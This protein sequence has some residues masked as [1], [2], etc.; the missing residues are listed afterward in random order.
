MLATIMTHSLAKLILLS[1]LI[2]VNVLR[3]HSQV[4]TSFLQKEYSI[5]PLKTSITIDGV[6]EEAEW[7]TY[8][9][10]DDF[11]QQGPEDGIKAAVATEV[12]VTYNDQGIFLA[13][14]LDDD[15]GQVIN[16]LKRDNMA[17]SDAFF[18]VLDPVNK[19]TN[20]FAFGVN[21]AG[22]QAE[23]LISPNDGDES[24]DNRWR[25]ATKVYTDHWTVEMFVPF[26]TLRFDNNN[27]EWG[28]NFV[29]FETGL[30]ESHVWSPVPRQ[31]APH[32]FGYM[33]ALNWDRAPESQKGNVALIPYSTLNVTNDFGDNGTETGAD[34]GADAK[35][36]I[37]SGLN[38]DLTVNPDFS[39][40][41]VDRQVTNL[42]RF[43]IFFP[44][45][46]Q[47]FLENADL[48]SDYGQFANQ[49]FYSRRIG[50][51]PFGNTVPI[52]Y[53]ARLSGNLSE[54]LRIGGFNMHT[55]TTDQALGQNFTSL[56]GQYS[57]GTRSTIKGIFLNRQAY[58][59][60][61]SVGG[62]YGRN[63]G[64]E[65]NLSTPDGKWAGQLG[66][67]NSSKENVEGDNRHLYGRFDYSGERFRTF[68]FVQNLGENY[69]ADMGFNARINNFNPE[70]GEIVRI[71]YTQIGNMLN[72]YIYPS[73]PKINFHW[74]GIENFIIINKGGL[75][76]DWYTRFRHFIFFQ[77]T[78]QLR[79]R[80]NHI[81]QD[82][83]FP[84]ALTEIPLPAQ[85]YDN[86]EFNI[87]FNTDQRKDIQGSLFAVYGGFFNGNK[88]TYIADLTFRKQPWGNFQLGFEQ[89]RI[90]LEEPYGDLDIS[91][92][93]AR[94]ELNF[95]TSL[96]WTTFFQYNTQA[97]RMNINTRLQWRFAPMSDL[98]LVYTDNYVTLDRITPTGRN[99]VLKANYWLNL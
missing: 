75:L 96:F 39:Q 64:G 68:L 10:A 54:K 97:E 3:V 86:W 61:E 70:T 55:K 45:R 18:F 42:T 94:I 84:F 73:S 19:K 80:I 2:I 79:F 82:L 83:V 16:T 4:D 26:R 22:A 46:R 99:F 78:S 85:Q 88:L 40:V 49:P 31:F 13:A 93:T 21:S 11:W 6:L 50:L 71:G 9:V 38:L 48:F 95:S 87:Q 59:G 5:S 60:S 34:I 36:S 47:F 74:S 1:S 15:N 25:S 58:D 72:Y 17:G 8:E 89:N 29:R 14:R 81:F 98:F 67:I 32:D 77:N 20:G 35:I 24:W 44:E 43:N 28:M 63:L 27:T 62:D 37:T 51:D 53:G 12:K 92:L 66:L 76:N 69:F 56:T 57:I 52:L 41:E 65:I 91:L 30:N 7:S 33:G 23:I 90:R